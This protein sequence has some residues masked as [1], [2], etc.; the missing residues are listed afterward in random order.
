MR[1]F[2]LLCPNSHRGAKCLSIF[3]EY[4]MGLHCCRIIL[5]CSLVP[6][7]PCIEARLAWRVLATAVEAFRMLVVMSLSW[8]RGCRQSYSSLGIWLASLRMRS[9]GS[10][11]GL[12]SIASRGQWLNCDRRRWIWAW[13][14]NPLSESLFITRVRCSIPICVALSRIG[15]RPRPDSFCGFCMPSEGKLGRR[16]VACL[17]A[18]FRIPSMVV[19]C[20]S[21][22]TPR[23]GA[24]Y[25]DFSRC[26]IANDLS[27]GLRFS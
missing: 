8:W 27:G 1:L 4:C 12:D 11:S 5:S 21:F 13:A 9:V 16:T 18:L 22:K 19:S 20:I 3:L 6:I 23:Y 26:S 17:V 25:L 2:Q 7:C 10:L 14:V 15:G 24:W